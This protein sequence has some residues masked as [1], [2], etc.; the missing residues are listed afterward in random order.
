MTK[1]KQ[2]TVINAESSASKAAPALSKEYINPL[3]GSS[4]VE[5][6][7]FRDLISSIIIKNTTEQT[8]VPV[9]FYS[10]VDN[11]KLS[12]TFYPRVP[13]VSFKLG[14][15]DF[16][17]FNLYI[18]LTQ[19]FSKFVII[20]NISFY[21]SITGTSGS[22]TAYT[23]SAK[24]SADIYKNALAR[25]LSNY[26]LEEFLETLPNASFDYA[27]D[28][29][30]AKV[31]HFY[32]RA[33]FSDLF[34]KVQLAT[35][36]GST[37]SGVPNTPATGRVG[38]GISDINTRINLINHNTNPTN[39]DVSTV[40]KST[41]I[42]SIVFDFFLFATNI[43]GANARKKFSQVIQVDNSGNSYV[44]LNLLELTSFNDYTD[45]P[46]DSRLVHVAHISKIV[47]AYGVSVDFN[48]YPVGSSE[49]SE[50]LSRFV[51]AGFNPVISATG[52]AGPTYVTLRNPKVPYVVDNRDKSKPRL[53]FTSMLTNGVDS[54]GSLLPVPYRRDIPNTPQGSF[55]WNML[56][57][58]PTNSYR[59][60]LVAGGIY[61]K[62]NK[63]IDNQVATYKP[64]SY[65][66]NGIPSAVTLEFSVLF[67]ENPALYNGFNQLYLYRRTLATAFI[68]SPVF[69]CNKI[70]TPYTIKNGAIQQ[71][72]LKSGTLSKAK[73][74]IRVRRDANKTIN[75]L[76]PRCRIFLRRY[77]YRKIG[78][79]ITYVPDAF[80]ASGYLD[81]LDS[82]GVVLTSLSGSDLGYSGYLGKS[83]DLIIL[84]A[85]F[86]NLQN[87][88]GFS[89]ASCAVKDF[90]ELAR[91]KL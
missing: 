33:E 52:A 62:F 83:N 14:I 20:E 13:I 21:P 39:Y 9:N 11:S 2:L 49:R 86:T 70:S 24:I 26:S 37:S 31:T 74:T 8:R 67:S 45:A 4:L 51:T 29:F 44:F 55:G 5:E 81:K 16:V 65:T 7:S 12:V 79:Q 27:D 85:D 66:L 35:F 41:G 19:D 75:T 88:Y 82:G 3:T 54:R 46:L 63:N 47:T 59:K 38:L 17:K 77:S 57:T 91:I 43:N 48:L 61:Q 64:I 42:R 32:E 10:S 71:F 80:L 30:S 69:S 84:M 18:S 40:L 78:K 87:F 34:F 6:V 22:T 50:L 68:T 56:I 28:N 53:V 73:N 36:Q 76:L 25:L 15:P 58:T 90:V 89:T 72:V 1:Q 23:E 60:N